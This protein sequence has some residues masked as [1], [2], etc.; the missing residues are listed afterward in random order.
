[1]V[2][3]GYVKCE[4]CGKEICKKQLKRHK[5]VLKEKRALEKCTSCGKE[6]T[7]DHLARH[8]ERCLPKN[9]WKTHQ[10]FF[11]Y[12]LR[13][14]RAFNRELRKEAFLG[15]KEAKKQIIM[16][17]YCKERAEV[18]LRKNQKQL[19]EE[20]KERENDILRIVRETAEE[21]KIDFE[22]EIKKEAIKDL[23][24]FC[25]P[26]LS[27]RELIF[28]YLK[29]TG[30]NNER[31]I[32]IVDK[33]LRKK[34]YPLDE[35]LKDN[36][37]LYEEIQE[38]R[39]KCDYYRYYQRF[40]QMIQKYFKSGNAFVCF[41]CRKCF[42]NMK[43]HLRRCEPCRK[44][45]NG[46][47]DNEEDKRNFMTK[48]EEE[49]KEKIIKFYLETFH[50]AALW[51]EWLLEDYINYYKRYSYN[52]F[53]ETIERRVKNRKAFIEK[54]E[55]GRKEFR[56]RY[57]CNDKKSFLRDLISEVDAMPAWSD[58]KEEKSDEEI[59]LEEE[60]AENKIEE[61]VEEKEEDCPLLAKAIEKVERGRDEVEEKHEELDPVKCNKTWAILLGG[62]FKAKLEEKDNAE[63][64]SSDEEDDAKDREE[65]D[66]LKELNE[67][68]ILK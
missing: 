59:N 54:I 47:T 68:N 37:K 2:K 35:E 23:V 58:E 8:V 49:N 24:T 60:Q 57:G 3:F 62:R 28:T 32:A 52:Y 65:V 7:S 26:G 34:D 44:L 33:K 10:Y 56:K 67:A 25:Y 15:S 53:I 27:C 16:N 63:I 29:S 51:E 4:E 1:M 41:Y 43:Q 45:F 14:V 5:C 21:L 13:I 12:L 6:V 48:E 17:Q 19:N 18:D 36:K 38:A 64:S 42:S 9:F 46:E 50:G 22:K 11:C 66:L 31:A 30:F 39:T 55:E 40:Y 61:N 20:A